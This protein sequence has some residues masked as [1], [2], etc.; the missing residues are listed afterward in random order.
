MTAEATTRPTTITVGDY[1][2]L[3]EADSP[4]VQAGFP[5]PDGSTW[6]Y[7]EPEAMVLV[8]N[9]WLQVA[10]VPYTRSNDR[11]QILDNAKHMYFS[12]ERFEVPAGGRIT[13]EIE[14]AARPVG[15]NPGN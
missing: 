1:H 13:F 12:R 10:A 8:R 15:T 4:W 6:L 2:R 7:K 9:G 3:F 11:V 14:I 5:L